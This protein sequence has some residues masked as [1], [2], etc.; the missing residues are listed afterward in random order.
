VIRFTRIAIVSFAIISALQ[1]GPRPREYSL[2]GQII[3]VNRENRELTIRHEDIPGY[4]PGMVMSF[5]VADPA[6]VDRHK[7][8]ELVTATLVVRD[9]DSTIR[10]IV[11]TGSAPVD[12][13]V[14]RSASTPVLAPGDI[15][16]EGDFVD[17]AGRPRHLSEWRGS[18][19]LLTFIYTRCPLPDFC[20]RMER[21]YLAIQQQLKESGTAAHVQLVAA[22]FDPAYDTPEVLEKH[23]TAIGADPSL[24]HYLTGDLTSIE[25]FAAQFGVSIIRNPSDARDI[26]HNLRTAVIGPDGKLVEILSGNQWTP[27]EAMAAIARVSPAR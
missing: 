27:S 7:P 10:D 13:S 9:L 22:T 26:T 16:P 24:W 25:R 11:V 20:P 19:V 5:R 3:A 2:R 8:G 17:E 1:C 21:N 23:A 14:A 6:D 4:M 12:A 15:V 18:V